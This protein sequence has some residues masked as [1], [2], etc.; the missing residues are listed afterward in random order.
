[1]FG[2]VFCFLNFIII[3]SS[4]CSGMA[5]V[6]FLPANQHFHTCILLPAVSTL[7]QRNFAFSI[8]Y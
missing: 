3:K 7:Q 1:M 4:L 5:F 6:F 2:W 8:Y